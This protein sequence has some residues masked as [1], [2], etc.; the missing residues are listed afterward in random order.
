[1]NFQQ[2]VRFLQHQ[3]EVRV[4]WNRLQ[5]LHKDSQRFDK[6][7]VIYYYN[8]FYQGRHYPLESKRHVHNFCTIYIRIPYELLNETNN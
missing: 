3:H 5:A 6:K 4:L 2:Q 1:M 8:K 7:G